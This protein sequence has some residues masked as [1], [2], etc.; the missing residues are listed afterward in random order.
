MLSVRMPG[1]TAAFAAIALLLVGTALSP[2][3]A[4]ASVVFGFAGPPGEHGVPAPWSFRRWSP[5]TG[6]GEYEATV[7]VVSRDGTA[8]L[9]VR[10]VRSG[11]IV[12]TN[13][14]VD[15]AEMRA[16]QW[17]WSAEALPKGGSFRER[18]TNDQ[19]LQV[20]FAFDGGKI[21][22]Y[23]WDTTG[24]VGATGSGLSWQDDVRVIVLQAGAAN[25]GQWITE[26]RDIHA[27]F[28][29]LFNTEPPRLKGV[30]VQSNSQ[31]TDSSGAGCVGPITMTGK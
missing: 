31:H 3:R 9:C 29:K 13:R 11:F 27:D 4:A 10:S 28:R 7:R 17:S 19:A 16:V 6:L 18:A 12:G 22:S 25:L 14:A 2:V 1:A 30:A 15:V 24:P 20:L 21:V 8:V 23:I 26:Q 5:V